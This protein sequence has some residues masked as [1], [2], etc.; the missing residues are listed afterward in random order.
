MRLRQSNKPFSLKRRLL[1][2][3]LSTVTLIWLGAAWFSFLDA[4][5]EINE[6]LDAH[7]AQSASLLLVQLSGTGDEDDEEE[8]NFEERFEMLEEIDTEHAPALH[9]YSRQVVF[10]IWWRGRRLLLHSLH[11]PNERLATR[12]QGFSDSFFGDERWRVFSTWDSSGELLIQIGEKAATRGR[13]AHEIGEHL[14]QPLLFALALLAAIIWF[15]IGRGLRPL[16]ALSEQVARRDPANLTPLQTEAIPTEAVPLVTSLNRLFE[17]VSAA[18]DNE[19]RFTA[20]AAHELR[21]PLAALKAQAQVALAASDDS[22]R[23]RALQQVITGCDRAAHLVEQLLTLARLEPA[24]SE[25]LAKHWNTVDLHA[26]TAESIAELAPMAFNKYIDI[27]LNESLP[28]G[29]P[30]MAQGD[31]GLLQILLRNLLD[32]AIRYSPPDSVVQ[33]AVALVDHHPTI[34]ITDQGPGL[35]PEQQQKVWQRF[36]RVLGSEQSGSGLGLSIVQ[37]I[38]DIH[39][40]HV[41]LSSGQQNQGLCVTM[42]FPKLR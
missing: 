22:Q 36:Y 41:T 2:W 18:L 12:E 24:G 8:E 29:P 32:N 38:A 35:T 5:R 6:L 17:R 23:Q 15:S 19:K 16:N 13:I 27:E 9:P 25:P 31:P 39:G 40:A 37:R 4:Q 11:A 7:L 30:V 28:K 1:L 34:S 21:T 20:D 42:Q 10:Q 26:L 14:L 3:L 33:V